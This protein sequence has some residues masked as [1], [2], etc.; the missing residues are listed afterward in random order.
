MVSEVQAKTVLFI[1]FFKKKALSLSFFTQQ[2]NLMHLLPF[3][4]HINHNWTI[5]FSLSLSR[6][7]RNGQ[8]ENNQR[9]QSFLFKCTVCTLMRS[10]CG[11]NAE[12]RRAYLG[13]KDGQCM[14]VIHR[15]LHC[16]FIRQLLMQSVL[17]LPSCWVQTSSLII[18]FC[19]VHHFVRDYRMQTCACL[20]FYTMCIIHSLFKFFMKHSVERTSSSADECRT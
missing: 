18:V 2:V 19:L 17:W 9:A 3:S 13:N 1:L 11:I 14:C 16:A 12:F 8:E 5:G 20:G 15:Q 10:I 7:Q 4:K 6:H